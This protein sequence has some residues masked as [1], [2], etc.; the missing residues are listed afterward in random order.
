MNLVYA[1]LVEILEDG[2]R[3]GRVKVHGAT[4]KIRSDS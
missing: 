3:M 1:K 4:K 2:M